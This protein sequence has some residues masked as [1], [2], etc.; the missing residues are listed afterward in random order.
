MVEAAPA[1]SDQL[2]IQ[3]LM[4]A[5]KVASGTAGV[6]VVSMSWG[7]SEFSGETAY[8]A[9]F[10]TPGITYVAAS[11]DSGGVEY[12]AA[13]P[14]VVA[15]GGT[16]LTLSGTSSYGSES[17]WTDSGGGYSRY[18]TEP[19]YQ[20]SVQTTGLRSTPDVS[21]DANPDTG[22]AVYETPPSG[23]Q[24]QFGSTNTTQGSWQV[25]GGTSLGSPAWAAIIA[26]VDQGRA[27]A[28]HTSLTGATQTLTRT[29]QPLVKRFPLG[30]IKSNPARTYSLP[31]RQVRWR[32]LRQPYDTHRRNRQHADRPRIA[33]R[34][35]PYQ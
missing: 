9:D 26:I 5:V 1:N 7:V 14:N 17:A 27:A 15:V 20:E 35:C 22:V 12:P 31:W 24:F 21:F 6:S 16:T 8:D 33:Q 32:E 29:L 19:A 25:V 34:R 3:N 11:G 13:S 28:G 30:R 18:E 4:A 2:A 23:S 10:T